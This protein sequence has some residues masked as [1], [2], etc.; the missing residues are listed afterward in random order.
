MLYLTITDTIA[1]DPVDALLHFSGIG[2]LHFLMLSLLVS[3]LAMF[4][5]AAALIRIRRLLGL[6]GFFYAC[7]HLLTFAFFEL[8]L[9]WRLIATEIIERPFIT[10]G[11]V[12][13]VVLLLLTVT[14]TKNIQKRMGAKWQSL[15]NWIYLAVPLVVIHFYWSVKSDIYEPIL[16]AIALIYLLWFRKEK[17]L[18]RFKR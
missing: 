18:I 3:P 14:S 7:L 11:F 17:L 15:H 16:Y 8:Q 5:K 12:A 2:S 1:G 4:L 10:V 6:Y 13:F 9:E